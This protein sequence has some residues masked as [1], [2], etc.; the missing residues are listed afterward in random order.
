LEE[1]AM[2]EKMVAVVPALDPG[3]KLLRIVE[4][5]EDKGF[6]VVVVDD[7]SSLPESTEVLREVRRRIT[8]INH[9]R[10]CGKGTA[11][12]TAL[13]YAMD[14]FGAVCTIVTVDADGQHDVADVCRV[15][16]E[17]SK[18]RGSVVLGTRSFEGDVPV[19]SKLG[20]VATRVV[21]R[22]ASGVFV[23]DTQTGL[24]AFTGDLIP[25]LLEVEGTRYEYE[26]NVLME[27]ADRGVPLREVG[28]R[29]IYLNGNAS[30]HF[31][32]IRDSIRIY[33]EILR[34]S[35]SSFASFVVDYALFCLLV[36][37]VGSPLVA[38]VVARLVSAS[39]NYVINRKFVFRSGEPVGGSLARYAMLACAV[40]A[41]NT[42]ILVALV[43]LGANVL[44]AKVAVESA[45]FL[46]SYFV[47]RTFIFR[48]G[49]D[50]AKTP[51][52]SHV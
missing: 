44:V 21:F 15:A 43:S 23:S 25:L 3:T 39:T 33:R 18:N 8:V 19:R 40:L 10:N 12:K 41:C 51:V 48:K 6:E 50:H 31:H 17:A 42:V 28:I 52:V 45:L 11:I 46:A 4:D 27:C 37:V 35:L 9:G 29:T 2:R 24:R 32:A 47:Q 49:I 22:L 34:Y 5:L 30:S 38:N 13:R 20:N 16:E 7:G 26:M 14:T 1:D 36:S